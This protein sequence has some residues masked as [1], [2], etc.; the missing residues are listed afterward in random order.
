LWFTQAQNRWE[1]KGFMNHFENL[2][3]ESVA[4]SD[5]KPIKQKKRIVYSY[6][7]LIELLDYLIIFL[8]G[9]SGAGLINLVSDTHYVGMIYTFILFLSYAIWTLKKEGKGYQESL[10]NN[11]YLS[12]KKSKWGND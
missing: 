10:F 1:V 5:T 3:L 2:V 11:L 12:S 8:M 6:F 7:V 9:L 4:S